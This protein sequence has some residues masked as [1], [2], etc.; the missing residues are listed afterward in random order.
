MDI[1]VSPGE[2]FFSKTKR[3]RDKEENEYLN[4]YREI[5]FRFHGK[6]TPKNKG[7]RETLSIF[8]KEKLSAPLNYH[9]N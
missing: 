7:E 1:I 8:K 3:K 6:L 2:S 4:D 9:A 5:I